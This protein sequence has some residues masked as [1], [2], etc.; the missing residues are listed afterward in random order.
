MS[1]LT[2]MRVALRSLWQRPTL[3]A[4]LVAT[5]ALGVGVNTAIYSLI[6]AVLLHPLAVTDPDRLLAVQRA[7]ATASGTRAVTYEA[8]E[9]LAAHTSILSDV[10]AVSTTKLTSE[11]AGESEYVTV[12]FVSDGYFETLGVGT[13]LGRTM[14]P[15]DP[16]APG[17]NPVV[18]MSWE[19]WQRHFRGDPE[20]LGS[21]IRVNGVA[22][23]VIGVAPRTFRGTFLSSATDFW[24][25]LSMVPV[26]Q[27]P[28]LSG[29]DGINQRL[30]LFQVFGRL[31]PDVDT[32]R[33]STEIV[34]ILSR[35]D[36][37]SRAEQQDVPDFSVMPLAHA[38]AG[39]ENRSAL[40]R[41][42]GLLY[43]IGAMTLLFACMNIANLLV[44]RADERREELGIRA[45]LGAGVGRIGQQLFAES[46]V[47]AVSGGFV[48]I[49]V[50]MASTRVL[51]TLVLPSR[52]AL[53]GLDLGI[54][55]RALLFAI[56]VSLATSLVF[57]LAPAVG[58]SRLR[59]RDALSGGAVTY[60]P[61]LRQGVLLGIQVAL[62]LIFVVG[63]SLTVRSFRAGLTTSLGFEADAL[64]AVS[65]RTPRNGTHAESV[66]M[67]D[68]VVDQL[69]HAPGVLAAAAATHVPLAPS[70]SK[71]FAPGPSLWGPYEADPALLGGGE[72][73]EDVVMMGM[74]H[75]AGD[76]FGALGVPLL[77]G[78]SFTRDD[79]SQAERVVILNESAARALFPGKSPIGMKV[80]ARYLHFAP[81]W[82][83]Y[84][85]VGLAQD[86]KYRNLQDERVPFAF[87]PMRQESFI[88]G[89]TTFLARTNGGREA[90][91]LLERTVASVA[92]DFIPSDREAFQ[93]RLV[94]DQVSI[95]LSPQRFAL[96]L[97]GGF[98][99]LALCVVAVGVYGT[100]AYVVSR[101]TTEI[102]IRMALGARQ[103]SILR[104]VLSRVGISIAVGAV[105]GLI[106]AAFA[107]RML[108]PLLYGVEASDF[109]SYAAAIGVIALI[110]VAAALV[111]CRRA[112]RTDPTESIRSSQ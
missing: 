102:G 34:Q 87:V 62:S 54:D 45:A 57:G 22:L 74:N 59:V 24:V 27:V 84:T 106:C 99:A 10:A 107:G 50:A 2:D 5:L 7:S 58:A 97:L 37:S 93:P 12:A 80:H 32:A 30:S 90:V 76:Y 8:Y 64:A 71:A 72:P 96:T 13:S 95:V 41:H 26:L 55:W 14:L 40:W 31:A 108:R 81:F 112:I 33:W 98:A 3:V 94:S 42:A 60:H 9:Q 83:T 86:T 25:P 46:L 53:S 104:L 56:V 89:T 85:V 66:R 17:D 47:L 44:V 39:T 21:S 63:T 18:V 109:P 4:A 100:V 103:A 70:P 51:S 110:A 82:F 15:G 105:A 29:P 65:V 28:I 61:W 75:I 101:R 43:G 23:T 91:G 6:D 1:I 111:P 92:P 35:L 48:G 38:A 78:R 73:R 77:A 69:D 36:A 67:N 20:V 52:I 88:D 79:G 16:S 68:A 19:R 49:G 11:I